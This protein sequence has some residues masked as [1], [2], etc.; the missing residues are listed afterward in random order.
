MPCPNH[1]QIALDQ[2]THCVG[3]GDEAVSVATHCLYPDGGRVN[4]VVTGRGGEFS[5]SDGAG[6]YECL[7]DYS[8]T[9]K[10]WDRF[11]TRFAKPMDLVA[12][13]CVISTQRPVSVDDLPTA[14]LL[15]ANASKE[16]ADVGMTVLKAD[17]LKRFK[18]AFDDFVERKFSKSERVK[19]YLVT[20]DS[21][22]SYRFDYAITL[23]DGAKLITDP[24]SHDPNSI[25]AKVVSH[26]DVRNAGIDGLLQRIVFNDSEEWESSNLH[27]LKSSAPTV[28]FSSAE[29]AFADLRIN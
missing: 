13:N 17:R 14:I 23:H 18:D 1:I 12:N 20:G 21:N 22:K 28:P 19:N 6:A 10:N 2:L 29:Q 26:M 16:A 25:N 15:V 24:V 5:V 4:V 9:P 7:A 27:L 3:L 8:K 11:L